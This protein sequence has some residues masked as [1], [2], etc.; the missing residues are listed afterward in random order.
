MKYNNIRFT[1]QA[2]YKD[3]KIA[4]R[5]FVTWQA[6]GNWANAQFRKDNEVTVF[7]EDK[8]GEYSCTMHA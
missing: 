1:A 2:V 4:T 5:L 3:G 7:I 6:T 8:Q